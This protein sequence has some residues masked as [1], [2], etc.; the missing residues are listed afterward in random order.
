MKRKW[1]WARGDRTKRM[2][3]HPVEKLLRLLWS[4]WRL[5]QHAQQWWIGP[6][7]ISQTNRDR[8]SVWHPSSRRCGE[9]WHFP[10]SCA[11]MGPE[12]WQHAYAG[13][14]QLFLYGY[15]LDRRSWVI[16][17]MCHILLLELLKLQMHM[18]VSARGQDLNKIIALKHPPNPVS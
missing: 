3:I 5:S 4:C 12:I 18:T 13:G 14:I 8:Y 17:T 15:L 2:S 16:E 6:V 1:Q 11:T 7:R 9:Q 10:T